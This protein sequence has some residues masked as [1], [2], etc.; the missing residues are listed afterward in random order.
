MRSAAYRNEALPVPAVLVTIEQDIRQSGLDIQPFQRRFLR[1]AWR[2]DVSIAALSTARAAGK[3]ELIGRMGGLAVV[4]GSAVFRPGH[5]AVVFAGSMRQ[6]RHI[7]KAAQRALP[8]D[9]K[10]RKRDNHQE[11]SISGPD[12]TKLSIYPSS[13]KRA[14]G[15]GANEHLLIA[16]EPASWNVRDGAL[17]WSALVGSLGKLPDQKL[18][19]IGTLSPSDMGSW[20]PAL[21]AS[22]GDTASRTFVQ[23]HAAR[24]GDT[25]DALRTAERANPLLRTNPVLAAVVRAE[26]DA[27]RRDPELRPHYE[28]YRLNRHVVGESTGLVSPGEWETVLDRPVPE[29]DGLP[30]LGIDIGASRSWS[31]AVLAWPSGRIETFAS[32]PGI[33]SPTDQERRDGLPRGTLA[34]LIKHRVVGVADGQRVADPAVVLDLLP[35]IEVAGCVADRFASESLSDEL[36]ARNLPVP[37]WRIRSCSTSSRGPLLATCAT[38][39]SAGSSVRPGRWRGRSRLPRSR[40]MMGS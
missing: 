20:W 22:G 1:G 13:G 29:R 18:I 28:A 2:P 11:I 5:E 4:P 30:V 35:D 26:R 14:L 16:D 37:E 10:H 3:T 31:A 33:P 32:V 8:A 24:K 25:W 34:R 17:L 6:A 12:E 38:G 15:L 19:V 36:Q 23:L 40:A 39:R 7:F 27:A 21:V 9:A